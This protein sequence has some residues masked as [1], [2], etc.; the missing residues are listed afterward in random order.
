MDSGTVLQLVGSMFLV[1]AKVAAPI[2]LTAMAVGLF[3]GLF[4]AVTQLND[5][6]LG[7]LPKMV[8]VAAALWIALPW[9][10]QELVTFTI[11]TVQFMEHMPR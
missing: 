11:H 4:Q 8:V 1:T 9:M 2:L 6:T 5:A 10:L 3:T 7:F